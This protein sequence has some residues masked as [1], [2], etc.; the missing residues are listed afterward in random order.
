MAIADGAGLALLRMAAVTG[1]DGTGLGDRLDLTSVDQPRVRMG[2]RAVELVVERLRGRRGDRHEVLPTHL[3]P[4]GSTA[5]A[6]AG[7]ALG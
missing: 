3:L 6:V 7:H 2:A 5:Q 1:F 4:R